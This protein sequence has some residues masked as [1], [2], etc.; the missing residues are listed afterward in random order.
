M[1][2]ISK[3]VVVQHDPRASSAVRLGFEREGATVVTAEDAGA[4]D[5]DTALVVAGAEGAEPARALLRTLATKDAPILWVGNG[6]VREE[7]WAAGADEVLPQPAFLRDVVTIGKLL[8]GRKRGHRSTF[9]GDLGDYFGVIYMVRALAAT[10]RSGVLTLVRGLRRGEIRLFEG[11]VTSAHMGGMHGQ[12][13]FHQLLL[14]TEARFEWRHERV[15]RRQQIPMP[16]DEVIGQAERFL[17]EIRVVSGGLSPAAVYAQ[18]ATKIQAMARKL[19][20]EVHGVLRLFDGN[21]TLADVLEDSSFRVF[22]TLRVA[23]RA[24]E[25]GLLEQV[26]VSK[27]KAAMRAVLAVEEW[28]VGGESKDAVIDRTMESIPDSAPTPK[29]PPETVGKAGSGSSGKK[30]NKGR[31]RGKDG[32]DS[33]PSR[34]LAPEVDWTSLIPRSQTV[35]MS[36][37]TG[38]VPAAEVS[39]E[40]VI[41]ERGAAIAARREGREGLEA[42]TDP[43]ERSRMFPATVTVDLG[44]DPDATPPAPMLAPVVAAAIAPEPAVL[45]LPRV[46]TQESL[47]DAVAAAAAI[48][49]RTTAKPTTEAIVPEPPKQPEIDQ[50]EP[51]HQPEIPGSTPVDPEPEVI[52]PEPR[53]PEIPEP[54]LPK[55][56]MPH[57]P[58]PSAD[59]GIDGEAYRP[60]STERIPKDEL[61]DELR[62]PVVVVAPELIAPPADQAMPAE[63]AML[64]V[65]LAFAQAAV[66]VVAER[67]AQRASTPPPR[68]TH[69]PATSAEISAVRLDAVAVAT[70]FSD[71]EEA[72]FNAGKTLEQQVKKA[73]PSESF[74]DLDEGY[75]PETFWSRFRGKRDTKKP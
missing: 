13:G 43:D 55:P 29:V 4:I 72:F 12:A 68:D 46:A 41:G 66:A 33:G 45:T 62:S 34:A 1:S 37:V 69:D 27:P 57:V 6:V 32:N 31:K 9:N 44:P 53:Q 17:D 20:T 42:L 14:W 50:P 64:A 23:L 71:D 59:A 74:A 3:V 58:E 26:E 2:S 16:H 51:A 70:T 49:A 8:A 18:S 25:S 47:A 35:D 19:P 61:N 73:P 24:V 67:E 40:I 36:A 48:H 65:D 10:G 5:D 38:V 15:V 7:A 54:E 56:E 60:E 30:K 28:L 22:E 39:G 21:R 63:P 52:P 75:Q 11:E